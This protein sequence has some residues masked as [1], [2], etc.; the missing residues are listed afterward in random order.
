MSPF[1]FFL[2]ANGI[3]GLLRNV[4]S[5]CFTL[6]SLKDNLDY[7]LIQYADDT[8]I[9]G[10]AYWENI[11]AIKF[12]LGGFKMVSGLQ[13]N[14]NT[15]KICG[16]NIS[17]DFLQE[18]LDFLACEVYSLPFSYLSI[19]IGVIPRRHA[20]WDSILVRSRNKLS[21]WKGKMISLVGRVTL[22][23]SVL[24]YL[25]LYSKCRRVSFKIL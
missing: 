22:I 14:F 4:S 16:I 23:N 1:L 8:I 5:T 24:S 13:V 17:P 6:L 12:V 2:E 10:N 15:S 7:D 3:F 19:L 18:A 11:W 20:T 9:L 21:L 25:P